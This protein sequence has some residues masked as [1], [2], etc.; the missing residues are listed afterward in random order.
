MVKSVERVKDEAGRWWVQENGVRKA[1]FRTRAEARLYAS[2]GE[3][4]QPSQESQSRETLSKIYR[5]CDPEAL[6]GVLRRLDPLD[7]RIVTLHLRGATQAEVASL[8]GLTQPSICYRLHQV[9]EKIRFLL[10]FP[11]IDPKEMRSDLTPVLPDSMD[12]TILVMFLETTSQSLVAQRL[13]VSQGFVR[14]RIFRSMKVLRN[15]PNQFYARL[16]QMAL[17]NLNILN[18]FQ[19]SK[20]PQKARKKA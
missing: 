18:P 2:G 9:N 13:G 20:E 8:V 7:I 6:Q 17:D 14:H 19:G 10:D 11:Q 16:V 15:L 1:H 4:L 3:D 12:V 5:T